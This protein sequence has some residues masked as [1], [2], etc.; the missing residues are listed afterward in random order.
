MCEVLSQWISPK[1]LVYFLS[2]LPQTKSLSMH[3]AL[4]FVP[5]HQPFDKQPSKWR[6][7]AS[8]VLDW[9]SCVKCHYTVD[10]FQFS[11]EL[12][13]KL[14]DISAD[15]H[16][17]PI[18]EHLSSLTLGNF[19]ISGMEFDVS[20]LSVCKQLQHLELIC[21][22]L[23]TLDSEHSSMVTSDGRT[24][25]TTNTKDC[26]RISIASLCPKLL[27]LAL[28]HC[29]VTTTGSLGM[30][31]TCQQLHSIHASYCK[32]TDINETIDSHT[33]NF[34]KKITWFESST[35]LDCVHFTQ[36]TSLQSILV[37][38]YCNPDSLTD[39]LY[40]SPNLSKLSL[41]KSNI[42]LANCSNTKE[43][44]PRLESL[45][46]QSI[47]VTASL[48]LGFAHCQ[49]LT[50]LQYMYCDTY[51]PYSDVQPA[52]QLAY[53][54]L[55]DCLRTFICTAD[56][57]AILPTHL[58]ESLCRLHTVQ[59]GES[60]WGGRGD[61]VS[62]SIVSF[63]CKCPS[64]RQ[65]TFYSCPLQIQ[66]VMRVIKEKCPVLDTLNFNNCNRRAE[67]SASHSVRSLM[68][69]FSVSTPPVQCNVRH[70][71]LNVSRFSDEDLDILLSS[72]GVSIESLRLSRCTRLS[73]SVYSQ[74]LQTRL[75]CL[76]R[77]VVDY[78]D[79]DKHFTAEHVQA[80]ETSFKTLKQLQVNKIAPKQA[81]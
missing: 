32:F 51:V 35:Q 77:L 78:L 10:K 72:I 37:N 79:E 28:K 22:N 19:N 57:E 68:S 63:L 48:L 67:R 23:Y 31:H 73:P 49:H 43:F 60:H 24:D 69:S 76:Q 18:L 2:A 15:L 58:P 41:I 50:S 71:W 1:G 39:L 3:S 74:V 33:I 42:N 14:Y 17:Q 13:N 38:N 6:Q 9:M 66:K 20:T 80:M 46:L 61:E 25:T 26:E 54:A 47:D 27:T 30:L 70:L 59:L 4:K 40:R 53:K 16:Y 75:P 5:F 52:R 45:Y 34:F 81:N 56:L 55:F 64:L 65:L 44:L 21:L 11:A 12:W 29:R 36:S 8:D 7:H 62:D